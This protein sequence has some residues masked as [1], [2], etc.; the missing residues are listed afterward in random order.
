MYLD[1]SNLEKLKK[2]RDAILEIRN[3]AYFEL[4]IDL[5]DTD[6]L[7]SLDLHDIISKYD[8]NYNV[9][10]ARNGEDAKSGDLRIEQKA[11]KVKGKYKK[12]G[13]PR[14]N[15]NKDAVFMF[16]AMGDIEHSRYIFAAR[17][18]D[19]LS[20]SRIY[21][22]STSENCQ[23]IID[24]LM[25][26]RRLWKAKVDLDPKRAKHDVIYVKES[27]ILEKL[28]LPFKSTIK[29]CNIFRDS[30]Q[31]QPTHNFLFKN[32]KLDIQSSGFFESI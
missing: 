18:T 26:Q 3:R 13:K 28:S 12:N 4:K 17:Y 1:N 2:Y 24:I 20:I 15:A 27:F 6:T 23:K 5:L 31:I 19:N 14:K 21:D 32:E 30:E 29:D 16:H 7:S 22:I 8:A 25:E 10:L 11:A 9:N